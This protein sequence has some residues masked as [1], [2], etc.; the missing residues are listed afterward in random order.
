MQH[1]HFSIKKNRLF[2]SARMVYHCTMYLE[3]SPFPCT[4][5]HTPSSRAS[6]DAAASALA[7]HHTPP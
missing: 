6:P 3:F 7:V 5:R 2:P 4:T 1:R